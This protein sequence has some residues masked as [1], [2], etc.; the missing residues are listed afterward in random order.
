MKLRSLCNL[1]KYFTLVRGGLLEALQWRASIFIQLIGNIIYLIIVYNLWQAIYASSP[2]ETVNGMTFTD[3]MLYL[4]LAMTIF[5]M[6]STWTVWMMSNEIRDGSIILTLIRPMEYRTYTFFNVL[7][8][9]AV[10][11]FMLFLPTFVIVSLITNFAVPIGV[12]LLWFIPALIF[13]RMISFYIDFFVGTVC[14]YTESTWGV[15]MAKEVLILLMSGAVIPLAF[16]PDWL[17]T[18]AEFL[19]FQAIYNIPLKI[20]LGRATTL[21]ELLTML[22]VQLFWVAFLYIASGL[23][24]RKSV[25]IITVNGG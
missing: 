19:P 16:F 8:G 7:G 20:L 13:A 15:D 25:K 24:W 21:R 4:V 22:G 3:T 2:D 14:L 17:R 6:L 10:T 11:L 12:N 23:F 5:N 18:I 1:R 9:D